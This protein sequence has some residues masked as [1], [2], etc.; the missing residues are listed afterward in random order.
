MSI[1]IYYEAKR[2]TELS[3]AEKQK[4]QEILDKNSMDKAI[5]KFMETGEGLNWESFGFYEEPYEPGVILSGSTKLPDNTEE[6]A[7]TGTQHWCSALTEIRRAVQNATW[8]VQIEDHKMYWDADKQ[9]YD[10]TK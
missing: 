2:T 10:P 6:A 1:S 3:S 5:E 9:L 7:W 4:V 8:D